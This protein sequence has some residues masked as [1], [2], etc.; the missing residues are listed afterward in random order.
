MKQHFNYYKPEKSLFH[1]S[2]LRKKPS[3][4]LVLSTFLTRCRHSAYFLTFYS[5]CTDPDILVLSIFI[6]RCHVVNHGV[7]NTI[8]STWNERTQKLVDTNLKF[9]L[10]TFNAN[11]KMT[12]H[13]QWGGLTWET[14]RSYL[15]YCTGKLYPAVLHR[16]TNYAILH[17]ETQHA[18]PQQW[19]PSPSVL[20][21]EI[22]RPNLIST[23]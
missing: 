4:A 23:L 7:Y 14:K 6:P 11:H 12:L 2:W 21:K 22:R 10:L 1:F 9:S 16:R 18:M 19:A 5:A 13:K 3:S 20:H 15:M 17:R 8:F